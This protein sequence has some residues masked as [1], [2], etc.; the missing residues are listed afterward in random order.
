M[1][2][3]MRTSRNLVM[4]S[5]FWAM[6]FFYMIPVAAVQALIESPRLEK[7]PVFEPLVGNPVIGNLLQSLI[8][9]ESV[10]V[11]MAVQ[12]SDGNPVIVA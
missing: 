10:G 5:A 7:N 1:T 12:V 8:P 9:G 4:W 11:G 2:L 3:A 6:C